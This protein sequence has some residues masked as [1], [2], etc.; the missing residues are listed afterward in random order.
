MIN[1]PE[2][3]WNNILIA[4]KSKFIIFGSDD[5]IIVWRRKNVELNPKNLIGTIK[6]GGGSV[7]V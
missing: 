6:H 7:F 2:T 1:K 4:D 5:H 3:Y